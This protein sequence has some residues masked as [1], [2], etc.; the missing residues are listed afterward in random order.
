[1]IRL[2]NSTSEAEPQSPSA[3]LGRKTRTENIL[4][5]LCVDALP[6]VGNIN[7][8]VFSV[9]RYRVGDFAHTRFDGVK[10]ILCQV[11]DDPFEQLAV[12]PG[13]SLAVVFNL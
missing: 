1:M 9:V 8:D 6:G 5:V 4:F 13:E 11:L 3:L 7:K 10:A 12:D 2:N